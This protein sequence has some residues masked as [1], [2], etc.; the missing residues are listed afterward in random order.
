MFGED[1]DV[2][3]DVVEGPA[4]APADAAPAA[5][6][7]GLDAENVP[8]AYLVSKLPTS[9]ARCLIHAWILSLYSYV[10][11]PSLAV[12]L[13]LLGGRKVGSLDLGCLCRLLL[14]SLSPL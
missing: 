7:V 4:A 11:F 12:S 8:L 13:Y 5:A 14:L 6:P 1:D 2:D 3:V 10:V 9:G